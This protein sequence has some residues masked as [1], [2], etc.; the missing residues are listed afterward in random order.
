VQSARAL[1]IHWIPEGRESTGT[2]QRFLRKLYALTA[3]FGVQK[4]RP[5]DV[6][7]GS[8]QTRDELETER[9]TDRDDDDGDTLR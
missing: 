7:P 8:R 9:I 4:C 1:R 2:G 3:Q 6:A 5:R